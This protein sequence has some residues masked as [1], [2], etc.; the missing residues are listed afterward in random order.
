MTINERVIA[1]VKPIVPVCVPDNYTGAEPI[2]TVFSVDEGGSLFAD[3]IAYAVT[4]SV[5]LHLFLPLGVNPLQLKRRLQRAIVDADFT[6]PE[7][8]NATDEEYQ[9]YVFEFSDVEDDRE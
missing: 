1:A 3:D 7:T 4:A 8:T 6:Y 2:Y 9:H 5:M